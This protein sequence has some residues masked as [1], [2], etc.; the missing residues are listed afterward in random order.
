MVKGD[1]K[2]DKELEQKLMKDKQTF[3]SLLEKLHSNLEDGKFKE[4]QHLLQAHDGIVSC[5]YHLVQI[6]DNE[7]LNVSRPLIKNIESKIR[8]M[9]S[10]FLDDDEIFN[11][12]YT[13]SIWVIDGKCAW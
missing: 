7:L 6:E 11:V 4:L 9:I 1:N 2:M 8:D 13:Y 3:E 5:R 12:I 10:G